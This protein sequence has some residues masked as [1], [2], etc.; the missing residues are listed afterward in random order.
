MTIA[1]GL[2][3]V[4]FL[5]LWL[6]ARAA[7]KQTEE[8][9]ARL[10][11]EAA[12]L[13]EERELERQRADRLSHA[14]AETQAR[15]DRIE[16]LGHIEDALLYSEQLR[17]FAERELE[18]AR[19]ELRAAE[20]RS[21]ALVAEAQTQSQQLLEQARAQGARILADA[22][23]QARRVAGSAYEIAQR[24][25]ELRKVV[26]AL[27]NKVRGYGDQYLIPTSALMDELEE[28]YGFSDAGASL[29]QA[30][31]RVAAMIKAN[32]AG[33]CDYV[34]ANRR[35]TAIAF[36]VDAFNGKVDTVL[37]SVKHDN[38]GKLQQK[39]QDAFLLVNQ[40]GRAFRNARIREEYLRAQLDVLKWAVAVQELRR[41]EKEEQQALRE[42]MREEERARREIERA[43]KEAA[44]EEDVAR[45]AMEKAQRALEQA[46]EAERAKY[47]AQLAELTERLRA[48]EE[49]GQRALSMAQQTRRGTVYVIS[50]VGSF[51]EDVF[52]I[53]MTRRL[54]PEDRVRELGDASVPFSFDIHALIRTEDA[55]ALEKELHKAFVLA[56]VN[57]VNPRK[58]FFRVKLAEI[59]KRVESMGIQA[60]W[61]MTA[62]CQ[63]WRESRAIE[64]RLAA[65][66]EA[67]VR[68]EQEQVEA[69]ARFVEHELVAEEA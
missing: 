22:E 9:R 19:A 13:A 2:L 40:L 21:A 17:R 27:E 66:R 39:V 44:R 65:D 43:Q 67:S 3:V 23:D 41:R 20:A 26:Q 25:S 38:F 6:R 5:V 63:E 54:E 32:Q 55:P 15:L 51:G 68:W 31:Q 16:G 56:Q 47:E 48:A 7:G 45:K 46:T 33:T 35:E 42:Q 49:R 36:V 37:A 59:R 10:Q 50:N 64:A 28:R 8:A 11:A 1:L 57:K 58:E 61:T 14:L 30:R 12:K 4:G 69:H 53:G 24:E 52:K 60:S 34:E 18:A 29:K 62:A